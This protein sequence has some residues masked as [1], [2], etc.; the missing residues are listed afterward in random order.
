MKFL[1]VDDD[2]RL[3]D[4]LELMLNSLGHSADCALSAEEGADLAAAESYDMSLV[5]YSMPDKDGLWFMRN[6]GL[7]RAT[8]VLLMTAHVDKGIIKEMFDL[9]A[10]GYLI[11]PFDEAELAHH[12]EFHVPSGESA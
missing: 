9:G 3:L 8:K 7:P 2:A 5:D 4:T 11:K 1:L 6:A 10:C 12:I